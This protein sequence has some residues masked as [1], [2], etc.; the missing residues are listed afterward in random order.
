MKTLILCFVLTV[1]AYI[2]RFSGVDAPAYASEVVHSLNDQIAEALTPSTDMSFN[3]ISGASEAD[4]L[5]EHL[6]SHPDEAPYWFSLLSTLTTML[7]GAII[8]FLEKKYPDGKVIRA[9]RER[10]TRRKEGG[11]P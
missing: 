9:W 8:R 2:A 10:Q 5:K 4:F 3:T 11:T 7:V 1:S 6:A